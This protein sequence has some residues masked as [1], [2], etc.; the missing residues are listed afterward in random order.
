MWLFY[1]SSLLYVHLSGDMLLY[2]YQSISNI[3]L[4]HSATCYGMWHFSDD[5]QL[6]STFEDILWDTLAALPVHK[7][8]MYNLFMFVNYSCQFTFKGKN[9]SDFCWPELKAIK[10]LFFL[11]K[12]WPKKINLIQ[13]SQWWMRLN[14]GDEENSCTK[15]LSGLPRGK[16]ATS[17]WTNGVCERHFT[18]NCQ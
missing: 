14:Q 7:S 11:N 4:Q 6:F 10:F 16:V 9:R 12:Y 5:H 8:K 17:K 2:F 1:Q 13:Q 3:I 18:H 15:K